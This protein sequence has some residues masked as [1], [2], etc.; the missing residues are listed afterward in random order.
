MLSRVAE[1]IYWMNRYIERAENVARFIDVN[2]RLMLD[3]PFYKTGQW[4]SLVTASGDGEYFIEKYGVETQ[5][6][7][8]QFFTFDKSYPNS[9]MSCLTMARENARTVREIIS[10]EMLEQVNRFYLSIKDAILENVLAQ[11]ANE[12]FTRI[13]NECHLLAGVTDATMSHGEAWQFGRLGRLLERADKTSRILDA[14]YFM[15]LPNDTGIDSPYDRY[16]W[17]AVLRSVSGL[18]AY[19]KHRHRR[20]MP[21]EITDFLILDRFFPRSIH[22]CII[23]GQEALHA[24][25]GSYIGTFNNKAEKFFGRLRG[26]MDFTDINDIMSE[27]LHTYLDNFQIKL[28]SVGSAIYETFFAMYLA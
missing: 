19:R 25:T 22:Y 14:K 13:K 16:L 2:M 24:I 28:N 7:V 9:I 11:G 5:E 4:K 1:S 10:S 23:K 3:M 6:N 8:I 18:E 27:G 26:E 12:F 15:V 17:S 20:I 21:M